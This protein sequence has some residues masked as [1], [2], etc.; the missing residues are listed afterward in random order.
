M[1]VTIKAIGNRFDVNTGDN[2]LHV[3]NQKSL[4]YHLKHVLKLTNKQVK[5]VVWELENI[6]EVIIERIAA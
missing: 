6:G 1:Q 3:L 4:V 2:R 5:T